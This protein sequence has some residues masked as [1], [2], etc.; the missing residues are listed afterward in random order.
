MRVI[1]IHNANTEEWF[2]STDHCQGCY[3]DAGF[4]GNEWVPCTST[5]P[6]K[7]V[8][9]KGLESGLVRNYHDMIILQGEDKRIKNPNPKYEP[10]QE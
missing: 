10:F 9:R 7:I 4:S 8:P 3:K 1:T 5:L 6:L 2:F